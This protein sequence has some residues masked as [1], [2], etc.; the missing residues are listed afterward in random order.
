MEKYS[1][2]C[3]RQGYSFRRNKIKIGH[4]LFGILGYAPGTG[5]EWVVL[6]IGSSGFKFQDIILM[7]LPDTLV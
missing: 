5:A 1:L 4:M 2:G 7:D 6:E 3:L